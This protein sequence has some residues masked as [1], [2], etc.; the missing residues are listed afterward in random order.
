MAA[1]DAGDGFVGAGGG[2]SGGGE[3][4]DSLLKSFVLRFLVQA[5]RLI[6]GV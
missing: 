6:F 1:F 3:G 5:K 4:V 2:L